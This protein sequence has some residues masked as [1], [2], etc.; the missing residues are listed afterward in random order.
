[1]NRV[2][3]W[4]DENL[5]WVCEDHPTK[6]QEHKVWF[7]WRCGGAGMPEPHTAKGHKCTPGCESYQS[8]S[9]PYDEH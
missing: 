7:F 4:N 3:P 6:E 2:A 5:K 9:L 8:N 1:M